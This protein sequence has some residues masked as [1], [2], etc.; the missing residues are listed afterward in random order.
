MKVR[1]QVQFEKDELEA[2]RKAAQLEGVSLSH[3]VRRSVRRTLGL[4]RNQTS[5][6]EKLRAEF[7]RSAGC[8]GEPD[9]M[10]SVARRHNDILYGGVK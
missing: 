9:Q 1:T 7:I 10:H 2:L 4:T 6:R 3:L 8:A 5:E